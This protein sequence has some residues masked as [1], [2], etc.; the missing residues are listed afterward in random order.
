MS[1]E[2]SEQ[3][4]ILMD[5]QMAI[6]K[7]Y[8]DKRFAEMNENLGKTN[9]NLQQRMTDIA[10]RLESRITDN[11]TAVKKVNEDREK[12]K[13]TIESDIKGYQKQIHDTISEN[14]KKLETALTEKINEFMESQE[15][16][17]ESHQQYCDKMESLDREVKDY[18]SCI[19]VQIKNCEKMISDALEQMKEL[20]RPIRNVSDAQCSVL[21]DLEEIKDEEIPQESFEHIRMVGRGSYSEANVTKTRKRPPDKIVDYLE[22]NVSDQ[23]YYFSDDNNYDDPLDRKKAAERRQSILP[24]R[25]NGAGDG[26][27]GDDSSDDEPRRPR[28]NRDSLGIKGSARILRRGLND[29]LM[30][31]EIVKRADFPKVVLDNH[32]SIS[33][34]VKFY[35]EWEQIRLSHP[36]HTMGVMIFTTDEVR[37]AI[38]SLARELGFRES[39]E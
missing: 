24:V 31:V 23:D 5:R 25:A 37:I 15:V 28:T 7:E 13:S 30:T 39:S 1:T 18:K 34:L 19:G 2:L 38:R 20:K 6:L 3:M 9:D 32:K 4:A 16:L 27:G 36:H 26:G 21:K 33:S 29:N 8:M 22:D 11:E 35:S 14:N 12:D 17:N 10:E